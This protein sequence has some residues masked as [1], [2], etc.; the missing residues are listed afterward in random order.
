[1][2]LLYVRSSEDSAVPG[3]LRHALKSSGLD[4]S[5]ELRDLGGGAPGP[6]AGAI[7]LLRGEESDQSPAGRLS[8]LILPGEGGISSLD[9]ALFDLSREPRQV[10]TYG[11]GARDTLS[12]S[13]A[14]RDKLSLALQREIVALTG[15]RVGRQELTVRAEADAA[16]VEPVVAALLA[17]GVSADRL[18]A[19]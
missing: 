6:E 16:E 1:M 10:I 17:L 2:P 14:G 19:L 12:L 18:P 4:G 3:L 5:V 13:A 11:S 8:T 7:L 9:P 15:E